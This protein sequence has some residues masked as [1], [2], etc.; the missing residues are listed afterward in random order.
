MYLDALSH[1]VKLDGIVSVNTT[2]AVI[3]RYNTVNNVHNNVH[4]LY[5]LNLP[6]V[7]EIIGIEN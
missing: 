3:G 6:N 4:M 7:K 1:T 5:Q 2:K